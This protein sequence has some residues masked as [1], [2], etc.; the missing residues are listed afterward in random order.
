MDKQMDERHAE[1][2]K[3]KITKLLGKL[4]TC[5]SRGTIFCIPCAISPFLGPESGDVREIP[6]GTSPV[7][8]KGITTSIPRHVSFPSISRYHVPFLKTLM[9][10]IPVPS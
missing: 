5:N 8:P 7:M 10:M 2:C 1:C 9:R 6:I 4:K 3:C